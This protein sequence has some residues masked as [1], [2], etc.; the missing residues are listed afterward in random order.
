MAPK[1]PALRQGG[2]AD[3]DVSA[4]RSMGVGARQHV[5]RN[6]GRDLAARH[7]LQPVA[8]N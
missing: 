8:T 6:E 4:G 1:D 2:L 3:L 7:E 5:H